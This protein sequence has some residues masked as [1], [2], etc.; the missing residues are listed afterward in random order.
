MHSNRPIARVRKILLVRNDRI[1]DLVLT[2]PAFQA[3]RRQWPRAHVAALVSRYAAPLLSGTRYVDDVILDDPAASPWELGRRLRPLGF[4]AAL[5][6]NT[7]TRNCLAVWHAG[8]RRRVSWAYKPAGFLLGNH[9]VRLHRTHPPLHESEF[10]LAF[11]RMLGGAAVMANL[12]PQLEIDALTRQRVAARIRR[13][14]GAAGPLF[15]VHPG[16]GH[17]AYNW[18]IDRYVELINRLARHGRVMVTLSAA[19]RPILESMRGRLAR[20]AE[21]R[22]AFC[23]DFDLIELA[24]AIRE[25]TVLTVSST[26]PMHMAGILNTPVVALFSPHPAHSPAKWAPLGA[27]HTLL[28]APL[29]PQ[30]S[31]EVPADRA[32]RVM[33]RIGV[34]DVLG[35]NLHY[36]QK[37]LAA[38]GA[39]G[40]ARAS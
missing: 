9:R 39:A 34:D 22:V 15:G 6:F 26:G 13:E 40:W 8:I 17:S 37:W 16:N 30:E 24:A 4:Q 1:G 5:V 12:S 35:A 31:P 36:A 23:A 25:Q 11:V 10:A 21:G 3:V 20:L 14:L 2:L 19:E 38:G 32:D 7:N 33:A 27:G 18:P 29:E 28:V